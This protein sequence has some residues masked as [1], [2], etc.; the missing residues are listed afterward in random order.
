MSAPQGE[1]PLARHSLSA[2][3]LKEL[4]ARERSGCAFFAFRDAQA[5][6]RFFPVDEKL[7]PP[8]RRPGKAEASLF[9]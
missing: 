9:D 7:L 5:T 2:S 1:D 4:L 8:D 3:E 6:L